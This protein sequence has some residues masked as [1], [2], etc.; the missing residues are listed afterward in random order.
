M[1]QLYEELIDVLE[2]E[3]S[4]CAQLVGLLQKEKDVIVSLD[5][6]A[7]EEL[8]SEKEAVS[9]NIRMCEEARERILDRLGF[10]NKTISQVAAVAADDYR[11]RLT[12]I[13]SKFTSVIQSIMELNK[14]NGKLIEKSLYY[15]KTSYNFLNTFGVTARQRVS[16]EA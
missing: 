13:A 16:L 11:D 4:L 5:P 6:A 8:L 9:T 12:G 3:F 14:L 1:I 2:K 7:L 15:I 10:K